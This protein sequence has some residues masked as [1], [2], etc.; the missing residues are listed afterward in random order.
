MLKLEFLT[1]SVKFYHTQINRWLW[2]EVGEKKMLNS[3]VWRVD[4]LYGYPSLYGAQSKPVGL[5]LR[6][7]VLENADAA[8]L[9]LQWTIN[10]LNN[11]I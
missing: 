8:M 5:S 11:I 2:Q 3:R 7:L 1:Y 4:V 6:I 10:F 9:E